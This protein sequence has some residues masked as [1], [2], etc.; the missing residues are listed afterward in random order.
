MT[1][2]DAVTRFPM[3]SRWRFKKDHAK[4][5]EVTAHDYS[6]EK[7]C[8]RTNFG[9]IWFTAERADELLEPEQKGTK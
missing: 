3:L 1:F 2:L 8:F 4:T 7:L 9:V 6:R 5:A